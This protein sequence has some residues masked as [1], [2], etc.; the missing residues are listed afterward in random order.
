MTVS[1][2]LG[3]ILSLVVGWVG[4][5]QSADGF[6]W[7]GSHKMDPWTTLQQIIQLYVQPRT[8]AVNILILSVFAA[9]RCAAAPLLL[10][11]PAAG[12][13]RRCRSISPVCRALS[14]KPAGHRCC[15]RSMGHTYGG[16][17]EGRVWR[18][19]ARPFYRPCSAYYAG[20]VNYPE[21]LNRVTIPIKCY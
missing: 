7:V 1:I 18:M 20:S 2:G 17:T 11:A 21:V 14:S 4:L 16:R 10:S 6:G 5:G 13:R 19:D 3:E 8:S 15:C 12:T 9:E